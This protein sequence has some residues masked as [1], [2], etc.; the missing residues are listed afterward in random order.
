MV[1]RWF[2][3]VAGVVVAAAVLAGVV[4]VGPASAQSGE[5]YAD[6]VGTTHEEAIMALDALGVFDRTGCDVGFCPGAP[7]ERWTMAVWMVRVLDGDEPPAVTST[8]FSD[9][10]T[11]QWWAAHVERFAELGVTRGYGDGTFRPDQSVTRAQMAAFLTRAFDLPNADD[12]GFSDIE[13]NTHYDA[14]NALA[15]SGITRGYGDGT[16]RPGQDTTRAQMA[17]F[18]TRAA[19]TAEATTTEPIAAQSPPPTWVFVG[20]IPEGQ[21]I[22]LR[23]E[24]EAV[25]AYFSNQ[26]GVEATSFTVLVAA[27]HEE[28]QEVYRDL[29]GSDISS[30][31]EYYSPNN[32][33]A[34]GW[35]VP[36][37]SG[38]ALMTL[39]YMRNTH[40][41]FDFLRHY[42]VH[43]YF[44]VLQGQLATGF[45]QLPNGEIAWHNERSS[46]AP[47]WLVEGSAEYADYAYTLTRTGRRSFDDRY[48]V[49]N[50]IEFF[51]SG[52]ESTSLADYGIVDPGSIPYLDYLLNAAGFLAFSELAERAGDD[53]YVNYWSIA[54]ELPTWEQAFEEAF[55][56]SYE[57]FSVAFYERVL[58]LLPSLVR[59]NLHMRWPH[60]G[61]LKGDISIHIED[62]D[63]APWGYWE[64]GSP[65]DL[66]SSESSV[67]PQDL[68]NPFVTVTYTEGAVGRGYI[69][70]WWTDADDLCTAHLLGSY[71]DGELT[72]QR[73]DAT[74][75]KFIGADDTL[76][77]DLPAH[78]STL[79]RL[80]SRVHVFCSRAL[81][82]EHDVI[83]GRANYSSGY[84]Q[85]E[86]YKLMLEELGYNVSDPA[87]L[88]LGPNYA[89]LAMA[90]GDMDY[91]PN[92][93]YP[94]DL[95]WL[96]G[97]LPDGSLVGDHVT[98]VGEEMIEGGLQG[99]VVT[100]S[101]A[102]EYGVY[103]MDD[104]NSNVEALAAFDETDPVPG[105][106]VADIFGC[107]ESWTCD[108]II[109][110][111]IA[112][113]G[114]KNIRQTTAD[115]DAMF[116]EAVDSV[117][118]GTPM[119]AFIWAPSPYITQLRPGD[120]V[121]WMGM[122][123]ILDDSN[124]A[125][126]P[127]G[128]QHDQRGAD[129]TGGFAAIG[130]EQCPSAANTDDGR[131]PIGWITYDILVTA[132][133]EFLDA[134]P[135]AAA[136]FE[137][138]KLS[139]IDVSLAAAKQNGGENPTDLAVQ[140]IADNRDLVDEWI[141]AARAA[142]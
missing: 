141:A 117:G 59:L 9:V 23:E 132:R 89:Y 50:D 12:A 139:V 4:A 35:V 102:D 115:Y 128:E 15:A 7:L 133:N 40:E 129:G 97:E 88:E 44:H 72:D 116:A 45:T 75:V 6:V 103:T 91:W 121:Y 114:W 70:L 119:I 110:N 19:H 20:D 130:S 30:G 8:R 84:F 56:I 68:E 126:Q 52:G 26:F 76:D 29:T 60:L 113:S 98:V 42:I 24:M 47:T 81:A 31:F 78:P 86:L 100:K 94:A 37:P 85:A 51:L 71:K 32:I 104:L 34:L 131:C 22:I 28:F 13:G 138:V 109:T 63:G 33:Q 136:L 135:V 64:D 101:F 62:S 43:E 38:G 61:I 120:N 17:A 99:F 10:D 95:T 48:S 5:G 127:E 140:W 57:E 111:Q 118:E 65:S 134:N 82:L 122:N 14:I 90:S 92:S 69:S 87:E 142:A 3:R 125:N 11:Q 105:N 123:Q 137:A 83:A 1:R 2:V 18:I 74:P 79:P 67:L 49:L 53:P 21:R 27:E 55:G 54:G 96:A 41:N 73:E 46:L 124:P 106:G 93:L 58:S 16:F 39:H 77:W 108:N 66:G 25:R 107:A 112:F 36:S 80:E